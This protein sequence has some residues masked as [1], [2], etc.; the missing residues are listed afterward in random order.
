MNFDEMSLA[1]GEPA[2]ELRRWQTLGLLPMEVDAAVDHRPEDRIRL[3]QFARRR[4]FQPERIAAALREQP[5]LLN[6]FE[7]LS[8]RPTGAKRTLDEA[9]AEAGVDR[10]VA[11]KVLGAAGL[12]EPAAFYDDDVESLRRM[13]IA[14]QAGLPL[15]ALLQ[16]VRVFGDALGRVAEAEN[17]TFH[18]HVHE[19]F[20]AEGLRGQALLDATHEVSQPLLELIQPTIAYFHQKAWEQASSEASVSM[21]RLRRKRSSPGLHVGAHCGQLLYR[22]GDYLGNTVNVAARVAG[23]TAA[24]QMLVTAAV[25]ETVKDVP[26][27]ELVSLGART[28]K[29]VADPM[30]VFEVRS[31]GRT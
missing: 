31:V 30:E 13:A 14:L 17:R 21:E 7:E 3:I 18:L 2:G 26:D 19:Q 10:D 24:N 8:E 22:E 20:R 23:E 1:M 25:H 6:F 4:G 9:L 28:L 12:G 5:D 11:S 15:D 16:L 27:A 29:G